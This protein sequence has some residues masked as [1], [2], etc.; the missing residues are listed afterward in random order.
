MEDNLV[1]F[2]DHL[3]LVIQ[4][5]LNTNIRF[6]GVCEI[7]AHNKNQN[8]SKGFYNVKNG[9]ASSVSPSSKR[10]TWLLYRSKQFTSDKGLIKGNI[11]IMLWFNEKEITK[12]KVYT[13]LAKA[14]INKTSSDMCSFKADTFFL[15][16]DDVHEDVDLDETNL[17]VS[18]FPFGSIRIFGQLTQLVC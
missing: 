3:N 1:K 8:V 14:F 4:K 9:V 7:Y 10:N 17:H 16:H 2:A 18:M 6:L 5:A 11:N 13:L 15:S 12:E